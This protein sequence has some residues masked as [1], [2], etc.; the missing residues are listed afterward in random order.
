MKNA[1]EQ[2]LDMIDESLCNL[3]AR[4]TEI[5]NQIEQN[6]MNGRSYTITTNRGFAETGMRARGWR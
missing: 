1:M 4:R 6:K 2:E 5:I 3:E